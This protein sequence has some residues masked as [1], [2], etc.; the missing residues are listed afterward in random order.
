[1]SV[2]FVPSFG[3]SRVLCTW[4]KKK[5]T[6]Q[7]IHAHY[8]WTCCSSAH[9]LCCQPKCMALKD[10]ICFF[11]FCSA[12]FL[13][14]PSCCNFLLQV[15][16]VYL[17]TYLV[18][19]KQRT[20]NCHCRLDFFH[21]WPFSAAFTLSDMKGREAGAVNVKVPVLIK[22][23]VGVSLVKTKPPN[24]TNVTTWKDL[25]K[26]QWKT[27]IRIAGQGICSWTY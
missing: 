11:S 7:L 21:L 17:V 19:A 20:E 26:G 23:H 27:E 16:T 8:G 10:Q 9:F 15:L 12:C 18:G 13:R 2:D 24:F 22:T 5:T 6:S 25:L 14:V 3:F 4:E 1:M